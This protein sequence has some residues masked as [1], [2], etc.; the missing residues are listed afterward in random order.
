MTVQGAFHWDLNALAAQFRAAALDPGLWP[1]AMDAVCRGIGAFS[2]AMVFPGAR[3]QKFPVTPSLERASEDYFR[4]GWPARNDHFRGLPAMAARG[5]MTDDDCLPPEARARS[6]FHQDFLRR[7]GL[8]PFL[9]LGFQAG[10]DLWCLMVQR[11]ADE[12]A[13]DAYEQSRLL[14]LWRPLSDAA[15]LARHFGEARAKGVAQG[16]AGARH[17]ALLFDGAGRLLAMN[18]LADA[19]AGDLFDA[20]GGA[21]RLRDSAGQHRFSGL[22]ARAI[23]GDAACRADSLTAGVRAASGRRM[24]LRVLPLEG[25]GHFAFANARALVLV[26]D[27]SGDG[28]GAQPLTFRHGLTGAEA[29]LAGDI[30]DGLSL[31]EIAGRRRVT[32]QTARTQLRAVFA[33]TQTHRQAELV[34]LVIDLR[35]G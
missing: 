4:E 6:P 28:L 18:G 15:T 7:H 29:R 8:G 10:G 3:A 12:P 2:A 35:R 14:T 32:Y 24:T 33:K 20:P 5:F 23:R 13:F 34:A 26:R 17:A 19:L 25:F 9:G 11:R 31:H 27:A 16:L 21:P 1:A 22:L 30:A